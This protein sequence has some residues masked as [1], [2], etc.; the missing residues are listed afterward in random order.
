MKPIITFLILFAA[1][2]TANAQM[3][4]VGGSFRQ[5]NSNAVDAGADLGRRN[6]LDELIRDWPDDA[7]G[8]VPAALIRAVFS[9][10]PDEEVRDR[11][12]LSLSGGF[13]VV[14][15][16][17]V[18]TPNGMEMW[19][20]VDPTG[21]RQVDLTYRQDGNLGSAI[22]R[23]VSLESKKI[24]TL[25]INN[26]LRLGIH[27]DT[28]PHGIGVQIGGKY[29][30]DTPVDI[31]DMT[32]G[33]KSIVFTV[34]QGVEV[35]PLKFPSSI[36]VDQS[37]TNFIYDLRKE[38]NV[39]FTSREK[40]TLY[41]DEKRVGTLPLD[42]KLHSGTYIVRAVGGNGV[43]I[44]FP[45]NV[46]ASTSEV[47]LVFTPSLNVTFA[48]QY[49]GRQVS[50]A[51]VFITNPDGTPRRNGLQNYFDTPADVLLP[52]GNY[53]IRTTYTTPTGASVTKNSSL[54]VD[55]NTDP[56]YLTTLPIRT[57][58]SNL[59]KRDFPRR[60]WGLSASYLQRWYS[61]RGP[62]GRT[63]TC[64]W[65]GEDGKQSGIQA[66][67]ACQPYFGSGFG[68]NTGLFL[69]YF[70]TD[71]VDISGGTSVS[72]EE[73][74]LYVPLH[75]MF[76]IPVNDFDFHIN[77]GPGFEYG[78]SLK[79]KF[80]GDETGSEDVEFDEDTPRAFNM[81]YEIGAGFRIKA[82]QINFVYGMGLLKS[83]KFLSDGSKYYDAKPNKLGITLGLMF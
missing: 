9:N 70:W 39:S 50:N 66:G 38:Y 44:S 6:M 2:L 71:K 75:L 74:D 33:E 59:F 42:V 29:Y 20:Y 4:Y 77:T 35:D 46:D 79:G 51:Q 13:H 19:T 25:E 55:R 27:V 81:Y 23:G 8:D 80:H 28:N 24:Y 52:Y 40:G 69:Q 10:V 63:H 64:D 78:V 54:K 68:L 56:F 45:L 32:T 5:I 15:T 30:G 47:P 82:L 61:F 67:I 21:S 34:P 41:I 36:R 1:A 58:H 16:E 62:D 7:N 12:T 76:R 26:K 43:N 31:P 3:E 37:S 17:F 49:D 65:L 14:K 53:K 73:Y 57:V 18:T 72:F 11:M 48:A 83:S 60:S 22:V